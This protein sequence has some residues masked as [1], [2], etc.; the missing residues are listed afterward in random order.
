MQPNNRTRKAVS[1]RIRVTK[2]GKL[3]RR[4]M[5]LGHNQAK[6]N[7]KSKYRQGG[8]FQMSVADTSVFRKKYGL[9]K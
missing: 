3:M 1:V 2:T 5:G 8:E 7:G 4:N 6:K 9:T